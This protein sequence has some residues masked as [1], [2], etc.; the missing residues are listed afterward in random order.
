MFKKMRLARGVSLIEAVVAMGVMAFG[1]LAVVGLQATLRGNA[2]LSR[3]RAEAVR[4]AQESIESWRALAAVDVTAGVMDF[5]EIVSD[6][7]ID[8]LGTNAVFS[9]TRL[10]PAQTLSGF[11]TLVVNV[12]WAD[13][14][15][16]LQ[17][18]GLSTL[19][20]AVSPDLGASLSLPLGAAGREIKGRKNTIPPNAKNLLD[21]R[22]VFKPP[23]A[24]GGTVAWVFNNT[25]GLITSQCTVALADTTDTL[26]AGDLVTCTSIT[27]QLL[28]GYIQFASIAAQ[29]DSVQAEA[30]TGT[31][32]NLDVALTLTSAGHPL[33]G[34]TC[35]DD[36][37]ADA[38][39]AGL[40]GVVSYYCAILSNIDFLWAGRLRIAP[41]LFSDT[42]GWTIANTAGVGVRKV[43]RY[44]T[45][46]S[47]TGAKNSL[48]PLDY[49][50]AGSAA[51]SSLA[52]QNYLVIS[53]AH[54]CP[55]EVAAAG[56]FV[57]ANTRLHQ[58]GSAAYNN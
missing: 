57:N 2:D 4:I 38:T 45:L 54:T 8:I 29:P 49:T 37:T 1:M 42:T 43:C 30:P 7:P 3:Q 56:D 47:D 44:T 23:Q 36:A 40:R 25:S 21:G 18:V 33:P 14:T 27:A 5:S 28:S 48:H 41:Q 13:R 53:A 34:V 35:F 20:A 15:G 58:D 55:V 9:R 22:S 12:T 19:V 50:T 10:V 51:K 52:N 17:R 26:V 31:S 24:G 39:A 46:S 6:G 11:K 32:L 16:T